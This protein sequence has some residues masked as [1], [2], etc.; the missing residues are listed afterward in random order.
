VSNELSRLYQIKL[1]ELREINGKK[2]DNND[3]I[4]TL[5]PGSVF[6]RIYV[7][8]CE[9]RK[10]Y[11]VRYNL[12]VECEFR[13]E[14]RNE[15]SR[16]ARHIAISITPMAYVL[17]FLAMV[18][19]ILGVALEASAASNADLTASDPNQF[20]FKILPERIFGPNGLAA[21]I[22]AIIFFNIYELTEFG[23]RARPSVDLE[24]AGI[25]WRSALI[26]GSLCGLLNA[27]ILAVLQ[28][29]IVGLG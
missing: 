20:W 19:A 23:R 8:D 9:R 1:D 10:L 7:L 27:K 24:R 13:E 4:V 25:S 28:G 3:T 5:E 21:V 14:G 18:F 12:T 26:I 6:T 29:T 17:T 16:C 22:S 11:P 15:I 2:G